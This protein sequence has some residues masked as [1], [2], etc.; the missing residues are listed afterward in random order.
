MTRKMTVVL[1]NDLQELSVL[2]QMLQAFLQPYAMS[3]GTLY[4]LELS[5]EEIFVNIVSYAYE[6]GDSRPIQ[7]AVEVDDDVIAMTFV[8]EG[9]P[10]NPL[11]VEN[12]NPQETPSDRYVGGLGISFVR[13]MRDMME[14]ERQEEC[15]ILR[16]W[17]R[18][19]AGLMGIED[20]PGPS[21]TS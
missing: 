9:H 18:R 5:L 3:V 1:K 11:S 15:N 2:T 4:A 13:H 10:F 16:L 6:D 7:F 17:F 12:K 19:D 14:Y 20:A 21:P 8:D